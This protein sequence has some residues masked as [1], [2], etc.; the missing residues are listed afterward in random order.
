MIRFILHSKGADKAGN[1]PKGA[2][3]K[4]KT[5]EKQKAEDRWLTGFECY[6]HAG[7]AQEGSDIVCAAVSILTITCANALETVAKVKPLEISKPGKMILK[8]PDGCGRDAQVIL[9]TLRQGMRDLARE[10]SQYLVL[11]ES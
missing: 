2:V 11:N 5:G 6:G 3:E 8:L 4:G 1:A 10:Y 9:L 7:F